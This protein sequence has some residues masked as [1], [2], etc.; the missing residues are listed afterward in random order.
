MRGPAQHSSLVSIFLSSTLVAPEGKVILWPHL[1][2]QLC[3]SPTNHPIQDATTGPSSM[4]TWFEP[5][6]R[7]ANALPPKLRLYLCPN[8]Y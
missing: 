6:V 5:D 4:T 7:P 1:Q 2:K 3:I 8:S